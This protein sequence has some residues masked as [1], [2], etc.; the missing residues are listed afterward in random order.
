[1]VKLNKAIHMMQLTVL[2][3]DS[4]FWGGGNTFWGGFCMVFLKKHQIFAISGGGG[5][6]GILGGENPPPPRRYLEITLCN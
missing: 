4:E 2:I 5:E 1:M 6:F 3:L